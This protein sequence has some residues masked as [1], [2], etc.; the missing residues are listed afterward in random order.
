MRKR[1]AEYFAPRV[2]PGQLARR[3]DRTGQRLPR[4]PFAIR[5]ETGQHLHAQFAEALSLPR[6]AQTRHHFLVLTR[7]QMRG[8]DFLRGVGQ[9]LAARGGILFR[10]PQLLRFRGELLHT[11]VRLDEQGRRFLRTGE[12]VEDLG[13]RLP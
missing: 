1:V 13:L 3:F 6:D 8:R 5:A 9:H 7:A 2:E 10:G 11:P 4:A 12:S